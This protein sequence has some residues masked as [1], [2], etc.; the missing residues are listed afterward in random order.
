MS[1]AKE[2]TI[3]KLGF[4]NWVAQNLKN[5]P[6]LLKEYL[7]EA[8]TNFDKDHNIEIFLDSLKDIAKAKGWTYLE[9]ETGISRQSL[10]KTFSKNGNPRIKIFMTILDC[11]GLGLNLKVV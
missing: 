6:K 9:K 1:K 2:N 10:Y 7:K 8:S 5:D 11:L 4:N 3:N